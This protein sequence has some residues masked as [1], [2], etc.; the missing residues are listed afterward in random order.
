MKKQLILAIVP[1]LF[2]SACNGNANNNS[3][4]KK[5][6][7]EI[8]ETTSFKTEGKTI[9]RDNLKIAGELYV[10]ENTK[11]EFPLIVLSHGFNENMSKTSG[12]AK[13][14]ARFGVAAFVYDFIGGGSNIQ[15][16][17]QLTD[18]SVLTEASDLNIV[19]DYLLEDERINNDNVFLFGQSQGGFISTYVA[20]TRDDI[21]GL[22][23]YY[24][25]FV[26]RDDAEEQYSSADQVPDPYYMTK[27]GVSLGKIF[28]TDAVSFDIYDVMANYQNNAIIMHGTADN[29]VPISYSQRAAQTIPNCELITY[30]GAGHGFSGND[31]TD[32]AAKSKQFVLDN[33]N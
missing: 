22:I 3:S 30:Q 7:I 26:I 9:Y 13:E 2:A 27:M 8:E 15:S 5:E 11:D 19:I 31:A 17:G 4:N 29:I 6:A 21:R 16:D 18:M 23:D 25:A 20:S 33:L 1:F 12:L 24:P 28:Y 32:A 10:P 14:F